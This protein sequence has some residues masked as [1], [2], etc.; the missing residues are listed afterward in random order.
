MSEDIR[1]ETVKSQQEVALSLIKDPKMLAFIKDIQEYAETFEDNSD[2][3][4]D[5]IIGA[6]V[7]RYKEP[8]QAI[9]NMEAIK[10]MIII[11]LAMPQASAIR[12]AIRPSEMPIS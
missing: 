1:E 4:L 2:I 5:F 3:V 12:D 8:A 9:L 7:T 10:V 11:R 6:L